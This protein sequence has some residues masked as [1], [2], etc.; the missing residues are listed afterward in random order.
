MVEVPVAIPFT[1]PAPPI[2]ATATLLLLQVPPTIVLDKVVVKLSH[3][4]GVPLIGA[5]NGLTVI[6]AVLTQPVPRE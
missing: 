1:I 6:T 5:G 4:V 3:N 2:V